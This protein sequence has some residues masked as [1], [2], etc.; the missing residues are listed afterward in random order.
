MSSKA[1]NR[2]YD[3]FISYSHGDAQWVRD[4]LLLRLKEAGFKICID[5]ESFDIGIAALFNMENTVALSRH[6]ILVLTPAW[7]QS[8]WTTFEGLLIQHSDPGGVE[9]TILP[10]IGPIL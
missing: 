5:S 10:I 8:Q 2:P 4:K 7:V 6:T 9:R 3:V 1:R